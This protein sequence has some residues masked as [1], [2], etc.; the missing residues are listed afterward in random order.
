MRPTPNS[1]GK[2]RQ[3]RRQVLLRSRPPSW[4]GLRAKCRLG[5]Q[6]ACCSRRATPPGQRPRVHRSGG[7]LAQR[8]NAIRASLR[9][10]T[11]R[12]ACSELAGKSALH[13]RHLRP[14]V[15]RDPSMKL[16]YP[17]DVYG[18]QTNGCIAR[19][20]TK[21]RSA[22]ARAD[23]G[24]SSLPRHRARPVMPR[25]VRSTSSPQQANPSFTH[26][27]MHPRPGGVHLHCSMWTGANTL[28][29][30]DCRRR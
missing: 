28:S 21:R 15:R 17:L 12:A 27:N 6:T 7:Q 11:N 8:P 30:S 2:I 4:K 10:P 24:V 22:G 14:S 29:V 5:W 23:A 26:S 19:D 9:S 13:R 25:A 1:T 20:T 16:K 18:I 3:V